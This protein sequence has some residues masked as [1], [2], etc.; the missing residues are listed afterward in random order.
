MYSQSSNEQDIIIALSKLRSEI[1]TRNQKYTQEYNTLV[2]LV[3]HSHLPESLKAEITK[4]LEELIFNFG[5][6]M[7]ES[8][9]DF[10]L[11]ASD[12]N[13]DP[14]LVTNDFL[15]R[16]KKLEH[17]LTSTAFRLAEL[18]FVQEL[19]SEE[20]PYS[21]KNDHH[22]YSVFNEFNFESNE[23]IAD[24]GCGFASHPV[25]YSILD[26][27]LVIYAED[28]DKFSLDLLSRDL[29]ESAFNLDNINIV[30]GSKRS[31]Q[32]EHIIFDKIII[33]NTFHHFKKYNQMMKSLIKSM[34][35]DTQLIV[36]D[37]D[38]QKFLDKESD[39]YCSD[40]ITAVTLEKRVL[41]H[42][43]KVVKKKLINDWV[44]WEFM[45]K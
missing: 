8:E 27:S 12:L 31:T 29:E 18:I 35:D 25:L 2:T 5:H 23:I 1:L 22:F 45:L 10:I 30:C 9:V 37:P 42:G 44:Y 14:L 33:H 36:I 24:I 4:H 40:I 3:L 13:H 41:K 7:K 28:I 39:S 21:I 16:Y 32:L 17:N 20:Y 38:R 26:T 11:N 6:E 43:L 15:S 34:D 19:L